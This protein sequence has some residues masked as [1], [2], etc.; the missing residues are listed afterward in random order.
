MWMDY[1]IDKLYFLPYLCPFKLRVSIDENPKSINTPYWHNR[2]S[3]YIILLWCE[4]WKKIIS[5]NPPRAEEWDCR[6]SGWISS[7]YSPSKGTNWTF[8]FSGIQVLS[9]AKSWVGRN[10]PRRQAGAGEPK[11]S[12]AP[13]AGAAVVLGLGRHNM[14]PTA[15][16]VFLFSYASSSTLY[17][18]E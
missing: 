13:D 8:I 2:L 12:R 17:P 1:L 3:Y 14:L 5:G 18:C 9:C 11:Q 16:Q 6:W 4:E 10:V 7:F 15:W